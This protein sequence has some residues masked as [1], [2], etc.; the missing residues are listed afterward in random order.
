MGIYRVSPLDV[1]QYLTFTVCYVSKWPA[2]PF[3]FSYDGTADNL[4]AATKVSAMTTDSRGHYQT[5]FYLPV[6]YVHRNYK[7]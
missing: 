3:S 1:A 7:K 4:D 6:H 5:L 2:T